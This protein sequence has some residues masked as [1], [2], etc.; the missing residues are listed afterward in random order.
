MRPL[1]NA[2]VALLAAT[3]A[4]HAQ[5]S[6][7]AH[8]AAVNCDSVLSAPTADSALVRVEMTVTPVDTTPRIDSAYL[9]QIGEGIRESLSVPRPLAMDAYG[10]VLPQHGTPPARDE[11]LLLSSRYRV[12]LHRDG[13]LSRPEVIGGVRYERF[14]AAML[15]ALA[16]LDSEHLLPPVLDSMQVDS[17]EL[18]ITV[19]STAIAS[20]LKRVDTTRASSPR[21]PLFLA[22]LPV[23][24]ESAP[25][26]MIRTKRAPRYPEDMR[27]SNYDGKVLLEFVVGAD[28][29]IDLGSV[30]ILQASTRQFVRSVVDFL[31]TMRFSPLE[32]AGCPVRTLVQMPFAFDLRPNWGPYA[33][34]LEVP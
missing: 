33:L 9:R 19:M 27:R 13:R 6:L 5:T 8:R 34:E 23:R 30:L 31:P 14:D 15:D 22:R 7:A 17:V 25:V 3:A 18:H 32:I 28:G 20:T 11:M 1:R 12:E 16:T 4:A 2:V 21:E 29:R 26:R 24:V 10:L